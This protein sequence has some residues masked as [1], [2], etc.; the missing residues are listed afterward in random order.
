MSKFSSGFVSYIVAGFLFL[1]IFIITGFVVYATASRRLAYGE[2]HAVEARY[3]AEA[4][5]EK[6]IWGL[7]SIPNYSG[8]LAS[9]FGPGQ[10]DIAL[11]DI[12]NRTK[13][14]IITAY[15]PSKAAPKATRTINSQIHIDPTVISFN[16]AV[17]TGNGGFIIG[18]NSRVVGNVYSNGQIRGTSGAV[19]TGDAFSVGA[20]GLIRD[21]TVQGNAH[22]HTLQNCTIG[23]EAHYQVISS[24][25]RGSSF[26]GA[27]DP[28]PQ[29]LPITDE[30]IQTWRD[31]AT[32]GGTTV[33]N[34][35][36]SSNQSLGPRKIEGNLTVNIGVCVNLTGTIW[37]T[38]TIT[39][40]NDSCMTLDSS[41]LTESEV[42]V[43]DGRIIMNNNVT[44]TPAQPGS[45]IMMLSESSANT[46]S[47]PAI[48]LRNNV[49]GVVFYARNGMIHVNNNVLLDALTAYTIDLDNNIVLT[50]NSG[51]GSKAFSGGPGASWAFKTGTY[52]AE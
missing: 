35:T 7:N 29:P 5:L 50:Y 19:I 34:V 11:T 12:N 8:E 26:P 36:I 15:V 43:A 47:T 49:S 40:N 16:Y 37:V 46:A 42:V 10:Y 23:G 44:F 28:E 27:T 33:G 18:N 20:T 22:A 31:Q 14:V 41:Y 21:I 2:M 1:L 13:K 48:N 6:A 4:G 3:L 51:F 25:T 39:M 32:A 38:G 30:N 24:C 52:V 17:Q 45:Y 9:S